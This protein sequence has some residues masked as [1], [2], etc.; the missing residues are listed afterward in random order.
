MPRAEPRLAGVDTSELRD[1][2]KLA[3]LNLPY[4]RA[5][6]AAQIMVPEAVPGNP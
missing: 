1:G 6:K 2:L 4:A 5:L 3:D